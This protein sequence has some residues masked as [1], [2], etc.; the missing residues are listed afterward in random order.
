M[1]YD[2]SQLEE[3]DTSKSSLPWFFYSPLILGRDQMHHMI[4]FAILIIITFSKSVERKIV[5]EKNSCIT[6]R[7]KAGRLQ[8]S[9]IE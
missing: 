4:G 5:V 3:N 8:N 1:W 6:R 7:V 9:K 2:K